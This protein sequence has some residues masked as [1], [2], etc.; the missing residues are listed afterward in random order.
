MLKVH[1]RLASQMPPLLWGPKFYY[2][3]Q[4]SPPIDTTWAFE[5]NLS[6]RWKITR[7]YQNTMSICCYSNINL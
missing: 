3:V 5:H 1:S 7:T 2:C 6:W 4:E